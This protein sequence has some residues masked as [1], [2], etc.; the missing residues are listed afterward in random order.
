M[1]RGSSSGRTA[2]W[3]ST[4]QSSPLGPASDKAVIAS[5]VEA[6][7]SAPPSS[8]RVTLPYPQR[9]MRRSVAVRWPGAITMMISS[10]SG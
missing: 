10:M 2:S 9:S 6:T 8:T 1:M 3:N 4:L 5:A 7:R